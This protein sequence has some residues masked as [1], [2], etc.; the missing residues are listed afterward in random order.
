[1]AKTIAAEYPRAIIRIGWE[2]NGD[3]YPW[4]IHSHPAVLYA[5]AFQT[6]AEIFKSVSSLFVINW[7]PAIGQMDPT[8]CYPGDAHVDV[9]G[10]D[11]YMDYRYVNAA[12]G[13]VELFAEMKAGYTSLPGLTWYENFAHAHGKLMSLPEWGVNHDDPYFI[14]HMYVHFMGQ[15]GNP[16]PYSFASYWDSNSSF[17][18]KLSALAP[19]ASQYPNAAAAF[20]STW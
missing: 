13:A 19:A 2:M 10:C 3:W 7:C 12:K 15:G 11:V 16:A 18:G 14:E 1:M 20:L 6:V 9:I 17:Q 4:S 5:T 8:A